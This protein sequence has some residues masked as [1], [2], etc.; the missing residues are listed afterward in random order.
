MNFDG[1]RIVTQRFILRPLAPEDATARYASWLA[2]PKAQRFISAANGS[3]DVEALK[4]YIAQRCNREDVLFLGIFDKRNGLHIGNIKYEP[5]NSELGYAIMGVLIGDPDYRSRGV[6]PE[7]LW[8][9]AVWLNHHR[10]IKQILLGVDEENKVAIRAY[11][12][13][14]FVIAETPYIQRAGPGIV[15]MIWQL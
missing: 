7:V 15:T 8:A 2:D 6:T 13:V 12:K 3:P 11:E 9:S 14:G 4:G 10:R 5:I 1:F